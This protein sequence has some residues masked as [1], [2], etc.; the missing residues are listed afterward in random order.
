MTGLIDLTHLTK[1]C[2]EI[3]IS[4][5]PT[6]GWTVYLVSSQTPLAK[7]APMM[8][9]VATYAGLTEHSRTMAKN[10]AAALNALIGEAKARERN[11]DLVASVYGVPTKHS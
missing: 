2:A 10:H 4:T 11:V 9:R 3:Y 5:K 7:G 1:C 8:K 6:D